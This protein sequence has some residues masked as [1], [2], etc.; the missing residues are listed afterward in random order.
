MNKIKLIGCGAAGNKGA[1]QVLMD[2]VL[3]IDDV[4]LIN[5]TRKDI[6]GEFNDDEHT[7]I[8]DTIGGCGKE[9]S[10]AKNLTI[11]AIEQGGLDEKLNNFIDNDTDLVIIVASTSGGTGAGSAPVI[12]DY[13]NTSLQV[14]VC[15]IGFT[16]FDED[17]RGLQNTIEFF[18]NLE[19][20]YV[21]QAISNKKF[22]REGIN[23]SAAEQ[24]ANKELSMRISTM[25]ANGIVDSDQNMDETDLYK[26]TTEPGFMI[27]NRA[28]LKGIKDSKQFNDLLIDMVNND[29]SL[30]LDMQSNKVA[31]LG[32][33]I[34]ANP[35]LQS[36]IDDSFSGLRAKLGEPYEV[37]KHI[38]SEADQE[39]Y[40]AFIGQ[41]L[42]MPKKAIQEVY[43]KYQ[44]ISSRVNKTE[45]SFFDEIAKMKGN[46]ED[47]M[48]NVG[49][50]RRN[51]KPNKDAFMNKF[52]KKNEKVSEEQDEAKGKLNQY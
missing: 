9:T 33:F 40:V 19:E 30:D 3:T 48:F 37:F 7:F 12:A 22:L 11:V 18:Q 4:L 29:K 23:Y 2:Q 24:L 13:V 16:G 6:P 52:R 21:V 20:D 35:T 28:S 5:S 8:F 36:I 27:I 43:E 39:E 34:N 10:L 14:P 15:V 50:R 38:Q 45:D 26:V 44:E 41:G 17:G 47:T 31:R 42:A 46:A 25:A 1:V 51:K 49:L 32:I